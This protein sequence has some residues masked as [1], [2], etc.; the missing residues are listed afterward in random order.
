MPQEI[1]KIIFSPA[2]VLE[3]LDERAGN[4]S[5]PLDAKVG[6]ALDESGRTLEMTL[7]LGADGSSPRRSERDATEVGSSLIKYCLDNG[8]PIPRD[9][10]RSLDLHEGKLTLILRT[11]ET[12]EPPSLDLPDFYD[13]DFFE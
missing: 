10:K 7:D 12:V 1:R 3:A 11:G 9:A 4:G 8:I 2:E 5:V 6:L 13:Y